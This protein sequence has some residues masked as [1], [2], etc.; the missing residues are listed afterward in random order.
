MPRPRR[1]RSGRDR[2]RGTAAPST[3]PPRTA[4]EVPRQ[5]DDVVR[6]ALAHRRS[7][8]HVEQLTWRW[9]GPLDT[10]RFTAAWQSVTDRESVLRSALAQGPAAPL[11]VIHDRARIEVVRHA[12]GSADIARTLAEDRARGFD[13]RRPGPLRVTL[14]DAPAPGAP[15]PARTRMLLTFHHALLDTASVFVLLE[16]FCRAYLAGGVLPGGERRPDLRDWARWLERQDPAPAREL[17]SRALPAGAPALLPLLPGPDTRQKGCGRAEVR[18][19]AGEAGRLHRWAAARA[20]PDSSALQAVW[21]LL[22]HRAQRAPGGLPVGFGVTV[23]GR[24]I[25]L[26]GVERLVGPLRTSLPMIVTVDP[27]QPLSLLLAALRDRALDMAAYEWV[28]LGQ[29]QEWTGRAASGTQLLQSLVAVASG[30]R[31]PAGLRAALAA[32]GVRLEMEHADGAH[33]AVPVA[34]LAHRGADGSLRL[35]VTHDRARVSDRDARLLAAHCA[36]LLRLLP[37][38]TG[39]ARVGEVLSAL[40]SDTPPLIAPPRPGRRTVRPRPTDPQGA[41]DRAPSQS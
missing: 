33:P 36:R 25:P 30:P 1:P 3:R 21:A 10:G 7:G 29:I 40:G 8:R 16:E 18:L 12:A 14:L 20:L 28:A 39:G 23:S 32:A 9:Q 17:W 6:D 27:E 2:V 11:L 4:L 22:I 31:P 5:Q 41:L 13:L 15:A 19:S 34:L 35:T 24:G 38:T 37:A 26:D